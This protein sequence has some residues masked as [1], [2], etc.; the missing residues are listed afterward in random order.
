MN[1]L[2]IVAA[3][4]KIN[5]LHNLDDAVYDVR[6]RASEKMDRSDGS[7]S[8]DHPDV[9]AYGEACRVL[10]AEGVFK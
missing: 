2:A 1:L 6:A 3:I 5:E 10:H 9:K 4:R 8:W 7:T